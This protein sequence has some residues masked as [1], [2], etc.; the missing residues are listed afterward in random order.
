MERSFNFRCYREKLNGALD[1]NSPAIPAVALS[2]KDIVFVLDGNQTTDNNG[3]I[4]FDKLTILGGILSTF[5]R[6]KQLKPN[7]KLNKKIMDCLEERTLVSEHV[8]LT[9]AKILAETGSEL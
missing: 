7:I 3:L 9:T 1:S 5:T 2:L 8:L 4:N 6:V